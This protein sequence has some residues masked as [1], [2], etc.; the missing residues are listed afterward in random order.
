MKEAFNLKLSFG[1]LTSDLISKPKDETR[2]HGGIYEYLPHKMP[3]RKAARQME[4]LQ[5]RDMKRE[6]ENGSYQSSL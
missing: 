2:I 4:T 1:Y 3:A 5:R 6:R